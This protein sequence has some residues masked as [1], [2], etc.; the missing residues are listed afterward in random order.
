MN[1][2]EGPGDVTRLLAESRGGRQEAS[3]ELAARVYD[4]LHQI[5]RRLMK[6]ERAD[7]T[8][9]ATAL[10]HEAFMRLVIGVEQDWNN[11]RHFFAVAA[12]AMRRVLVD[13]ARARTADKRG[14]ALHR[15]DFNEPAVFDGDNLEEVIDIDRALAR[16]ELQDARQARVVELRFFAGLSEEAIAEL[17]N[18]SVRT[19]KRDWRMARAWLRAE[20]AQHR[21]ETSP[22]TQPDQHR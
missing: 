11:R 4:E 12:M 16:L 21:G 9:Q 22:G 6:Q 17:L 7:H 3:A 8:L 5:A 13:Y 1:V 20:L 19:I 18:V 2:V 15:V 10:V 14:G